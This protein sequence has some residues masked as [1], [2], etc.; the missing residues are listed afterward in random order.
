MGKNIK[1]CFVGDLS[2][3][4]I[5][6]DYNILKKHFDVT[7]I[8]P[9]KNKFKWLKYLLNVKSITKNSD[10]VFCWFAGWHSVVGV[11]YAKHYGKKS[12]VVVG[13]YD[14]AYEPDINYGAYTNLK[15]KIPSRYVLKNADLILPFSNSSKN[16]LL[17]QVNPTN[18]K[19]LYLGIDTEKFRKNSDKEKNLI[20]TVGNINWSNLKRKGIETFVKS[21]L[22]IPDKKFVLIGKFVDDSIEYLKS[23]ASSNVEFTGY[24]SDD[25]LI[26]LV[27][28]AK[29]YVQAS[30][31]EGFGLAMAEAMSCEAIPVVTRRGAIPEVVGEAGLYI[32]YDNPKDAAEKIKKAFHSSSRYGTIA[33][34]RIEEK[35]S[36]SKREKESIDIINSLLQVK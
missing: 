6:N 31:H 1:I 34:R 10:V 2:A 8:E 14:T 28:R 23:I 24:I 12:V 16:E 22:Y 27:Q 15:E 33:R 25:E 20:I 18:L 7:L 13:G 19:V 11:F 36:I 29:V 5:K 32:E 30:A 21:A 17:K 4:F 3:T 9:L 35:F 26:E